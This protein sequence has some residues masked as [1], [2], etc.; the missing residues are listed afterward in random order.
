MADKDQ[1]RLTK[2]RLALTIDEVGKPKDFGESEKLNDREKYEAI[3]FFLMSGALWFNLATTP[4]I[5]VFPEL[6]AYFFNFLWLSELLW[7]LDIAR[8]ILLQH[9][10]G[11]D[12][13]EAA[14]YY[15]KTTLILDVMA[16][17]PQVSSGMNPTFIVFKNIRIYSIWLLHFPYEFIMK[18]CFTEKDKHELWVMV[19]A[20]ST[21]CQIMILLHYLGCC[22]VFIGS[23]YFEDMEPG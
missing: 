20:V 22:F 1:Y 11:M 10:P 17:L 2:V 6:N 18:T 12:S 3:W 8:K 4:A 13:F 5:M 14:V 23:D 9:K 7:L 15:M 19:Y 16:T 21:F